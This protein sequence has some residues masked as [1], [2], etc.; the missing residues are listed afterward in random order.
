MERK[1]IHS[2]D[3]IKGAAIILV[4]LGHAISGVMDGINGDQ[5]NVLSIIYDLVESFQMPLFF[6]ISGFLFYYVNYEND[7]RYVDHIKK[8]LI[9]YGIPYITGTLIYVGIG[10]VTHDSKYTVN[11]LLHFLHMPISHFWF[12]YVMILTNLFVVF[13][14]FVIFIFFIF[15]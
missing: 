2:I 11:A 8:R 6:V 12:L 9:D 7:F 14:G 5:Y 4:V 15:I 1:K 13:I 10:I 3:R